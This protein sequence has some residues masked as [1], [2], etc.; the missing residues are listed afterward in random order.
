MSSPATVKTPCKRVS[1]LLAASSS[2]VLASG[3]P[4]TP[5][6]RKRC[7]RPARSLL[8]AVASSS[9]LQVDSNKLARSFPSKVMRLT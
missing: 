2:S 9:V 1:S 5:A 8:R 3:L 4:M 7:A 6:L